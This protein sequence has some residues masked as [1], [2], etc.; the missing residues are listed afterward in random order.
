[1]R[2]GTSAKVAEVGF[3]H[4]ADLSIERKRQAALSELSK[5]DRADRTVCPLM[6]IMAPRLH[7]HSLGL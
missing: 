7:F 3:V 5:I 6:N 4:L 1:M 2:A